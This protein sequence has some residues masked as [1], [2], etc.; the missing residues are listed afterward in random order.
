MHPAHTHQTPI[1]LPN[2]GVGVETQNHL[3]LRTMDIDVRIRT[4]NFWLKFSGFKSFLEIFLM[5][6]ENKNI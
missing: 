3:Q 5:K 1:A 2:A 6:K 4:G